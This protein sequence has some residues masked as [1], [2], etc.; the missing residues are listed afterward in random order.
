MI[1]V[2]LSIV[3]LSCV[4]GGRAI[5]QQASNLKG[6]SHLGLLV[7]PLDQEAQRCGIT[8]DLIRDA[9]AYAI[10]SSKL[11]FSDNEGSGPKIYVGVAALIQRQPLQCVSNISFNVVNFQRIQLDYTDEPPR[12]VTIQLWSDDWLEVSIPERHSQSVRGAI[13]G[14]TKKLVAA[15]YLANNP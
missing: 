14:A 7:D 3:L 9:I 1:R 15:W 11:T 4:V 6:L 8:R 12:F 5:A 10:S 13:E 2:F